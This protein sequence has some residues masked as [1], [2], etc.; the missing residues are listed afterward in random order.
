MTIRHEEGLKFWH[1]GRLLD[2]GAA[3][4]NLRSKPG[5][6]DRFRAPRARDVQPL[7]VQ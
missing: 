5:T 2:I 4:G 3:D 7:L 1:Y 6:I